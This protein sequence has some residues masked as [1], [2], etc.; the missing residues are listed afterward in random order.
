MEYALASAEL[1]DVPDHHRPRQL[2]KE[3]PTL[4]ERRK[5]ADV[6]NATL[7]RLT[8]LRQTEANGVASRFVL[9]NLSIR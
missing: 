9:R 4:V 7:N 3:L 2:I 6:D 1:R 8:E 5:S